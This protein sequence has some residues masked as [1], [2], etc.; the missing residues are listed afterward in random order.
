MSLRGKPEDRSSRPGQAGVE[1]AAHCWKVPLLGGAEPP[2]NVDTA[3]VQHSVGSRWGRTIPRNQFYSHDLATRVRIQSAFFRSRRR[4]THSG[5]ASS[6]SVSVGTARWT[7]SLRTVTGIALDALHR[8]L[9]RPWHRAIRSVFVR[10]ACRVAHRPVRDGD[11]FDGGIAGPASRPR[12]SSHRS[13]SLDSI[14]AGSGPDRPRAATE[15]RSEPISASGRR[16][17][18]TNRPPKLSV[19]IP[20]VPGRKEPRNAG[21][22]HLPGRNVYQETAHEP[23]PDCHDSTE[24][25]NQRPATKGLH[26]DARESNEC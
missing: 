1:P 26:G 16:L 23:R 20:R 17:T 14:I 4:I 9:G 18:Q 25:T 24:Q 5:R 15:T 3:D 21:H 11:Y 10:G 8:V 19:A 6:Q 7:G 2:L 12:N 13:G 22:G